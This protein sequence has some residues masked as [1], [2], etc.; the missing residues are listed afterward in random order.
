ML[1]RIAETVQIKPIVE[2]RNI[3]NEDVCMSLR[4]RST[5]FYEISVAVPTL[6]EAASDS[7]IR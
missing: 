4:K 5:P 7:A 6:K 3:S 2:V 1:E